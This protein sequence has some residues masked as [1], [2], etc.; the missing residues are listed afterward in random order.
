MH[1]ERILPSEELVALMLEG[2]ELNGTE[3]VLELGSPTAYPAALL[4]ALASEVFS[5]V[6]SQELAQE[7]GREL[8]ALG[9]HNARA[10]RTEV[11][12]GWP[13]G[14]PY[15]AIIIAAGTSS[16]PSELIDQLEIG[17]RLVAA[18][19][20]ADAQLVV[21][22]HRR[23]TAVDSETL[24]ACHVG[25]LGGPRRVPTPFPWTKAT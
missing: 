6:P 24:G 8:A 21:R 17:G 9:C 12:R 23:A 4:S 11:S 5:A 20:D 10:V 19:G 15:Q 3:R 1:R 18:M 13:E 16:V 7:R 14:A 2:L 25:M 22:L